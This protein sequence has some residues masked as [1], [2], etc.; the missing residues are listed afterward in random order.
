MDVP[1]PPNFST[2]LVAEL[3][4]PL[5]WAG[6]P[7]PEPYAAFIAASGEPA[8]ELGCGQGDPLL[9]LRARGLDVEGLDASADRLAR[10]RL[11]AEADGVEV[12]VHHSTIEAME[13]RRRYQSIFLAGP[14][15]NLLPDDDTAWHALDRIRAHL[16]PGGAALVPLFIPERT[17][18]STFGVART[19]ITADGAEMRVTAV[20]ETRDVA[21]RLQVT[22]LRY[23][24]IGSDGGVDMVE[25]PWVLHWHTQDGF[26]SLAEEAGLTVS[27][28]LRPDGS[29]AE[30][31]DTTFAFRLTPDPAWDRPRTSRPTGG[32]AMM[33][34]A[35]FGLEQAIFGER[36]KVQ[37]VAEAEADGLDRGDIELDLDDPARSRITIQEEE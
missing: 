24:L 34:A 32:G 36:P 12:V 37:V 18:R 26:R 25:R 13:L 35:M 23:E 30:P 2:D 20:S 27:T 21:Q 29:P 22:V 14:T 10:L 3:Y 1:E 6:V 16:E 9:A 8:L 5:R 4:A 11:R 7:D 33:A 31:D 28:V 17:P 15:F 19:H